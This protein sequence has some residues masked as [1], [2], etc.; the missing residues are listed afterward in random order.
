VNIL[1]I[2][3]ASSFVAAIATA[4]ATMNSSSGSNSNWLAICADD[5]QCT[6]SLECW[7]GVCTK[8]CTTASDCS[9]L[10]LAT[11][12]MDRALAICGGPATK[13]GCTVGC[14]NDEDCKSLGADT[15]CSEGSCTKSA[16]DGDGGRS[17]CKRTPD[18]ASGRLAGLFQNADHHCSLDSDCHG[19]TGIS[20]GNP[21]GFPYVSMTGWASIESDVA[22]IETDLCD[23]FFAAGCQT[24]VYF[25]CNLGDPICSN[26]SC[27]NSGGILGNGKNPDGGAATCDELTSQLGR[28][29]EVHAQ[30][31]DRTC[32][33]DD[34]CTVAGLDFRCYHACGSG[35][36]SKAGAAALATELTALETEF[37]PAFEGAGCV[38]FVPSCVPP[39]LGLKCVSNLCDYA[40]Q[41]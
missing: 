30:I 8:V 37:C 34:D 19:A 28:R 7:C 12:D 17:L 1:R 39:P 13:L 9:S 22:K 2:V 27:E 21:C 25:G 15:R 36:L 20:C 18:L 29:V 10:T 11:C 41:P 26:G 33:T 14:K 4:C 35:P 3:I 24:P 5:S 40:Q 6:G 32:T 16:L 38:S 31:A 23:P